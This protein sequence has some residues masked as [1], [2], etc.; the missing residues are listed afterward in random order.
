MERTR[1]KWPPLKILLVSQEFPPE[2]AFGGIGSQNHAKAHGLAA[3]GHEVHVLSHSVDDERRELRD[4]PVHVTR[5]PGPDHVLTVR[6]D[7]VRWLAYS[8]QVAITIDDLHARHSFDLVEFPD[9]GSEAFIYLLNRGKENYIPTVIHLHGPVVM[10]AH[11]I[12]WPDVQSEFFRVASAMESTCLRLADAVFSS[13]RCSAKWCGEYHGLNWEQ[14]PVM[15]TG[16]DCDKFHPT[17]AP[18]ASSPTIVFV[19]K[20]ERNKGVVELVEAGCALAHEF[21]ELTLRVIGRGDNGLIEQLRSRVLSNGTPNLLEFIG[22]VPR[23]ALPAILANSHVFAAPSIYEGGPG[24]VYLEAMAC[25]LPV[26]A[27]EGSGASEVVTSDVTGILV[28]PNDVAAL[29]QSLREL[30]SNPAKRIRMGQLAREYVERDAASDTCMRRIE[31]FYRDTVNRAH[32]TPGVT[33]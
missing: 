14:V 25:G 26:I 8:T 16:I 24:F 28:P 7:A 21:P 27:C 3:M 2:T 17:D 5:I 22:F 9:W 4:G 1:A 33:C 13:S 20:I 11:A 31:A 15:H 18:K 10:F 19:G 29:S 23:E 32:Y 30:L 6:S 12:G